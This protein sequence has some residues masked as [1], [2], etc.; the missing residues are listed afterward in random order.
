MTDETRHS[1]V[2]HVEKVLRQI[3][4][5]C[6]EKFGGDDEHDALNDIFR[7]VNFAL[8]GRQPEGDQ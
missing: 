3:Q 2:S 1:Q 7:I 4:K 6:T 8:H 5:I